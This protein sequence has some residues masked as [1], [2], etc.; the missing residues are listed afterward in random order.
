[1]TIRGMM[2]QLKKMMFDA[3]VAGPGGGAGASDKPGAPKKDP[4]SFGFVIA[5]GPGEFY[6]VGQDFMVDFARNGKLAEIDFVE[7]GRFKDGRWIPGR[8]LNG[9]ELVTLLPASGIGVVRV[10]LLEPGS[11]SPH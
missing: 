3:G 1:M 8:R 10:K 2:A 6:L 7:E 4:T 9:D 11:S 5:G